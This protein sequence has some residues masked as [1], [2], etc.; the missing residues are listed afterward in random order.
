MTAFSPTS[1]ARPGEQITT[2]P[3]GLKVTSA[4]RLMVDSMVRMIQKAENHSVEDKLDEES[5][6][7]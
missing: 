6:N 5:N 1:Y 7:N 3:S 4:K 2:T